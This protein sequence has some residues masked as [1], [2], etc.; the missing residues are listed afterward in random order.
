MAKELFYIVHVTCDKSEG[1]K[2][3]SKS[4]AGWVINFVPSVVR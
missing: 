1:R 2:A 4:C 3:I